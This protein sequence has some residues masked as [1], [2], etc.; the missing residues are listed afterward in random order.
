MSDTYTH[1]TAPLS[2][3]SGKTRAYMAWKSIPHR[4]QQVS[5]SVYKNKIVPA[6]GRP[7]IP[8]L[9][10]AD[11]TVVQDTTEIIDFLEARYPQP[12]I[13]PDGPV[14]KLVA[15]LME[16]YGDEW[17]LIP[18]M[19]YRWA[20]NVPWVYG[21]FG[22]IALPGAPG[23]LRRFVGKLIS[24]KFRGFVPML[25]I[26]D[27]TIPAIEKSYEALLAELDAH[28]AQHAYLLGNRPSIGDYGLI[29]PL[30]AHLY[31]DPAS[32]K[33]MKRLAPHVAAWVERVEF[34]DTP[35]QGDFLDGDQVP[36]TLLPI[37]RRQMVEQMPVLQRTAQML[38]EWR[39]AHP[40]AEE[41]PRSLG[42]LDFTMEGVTGQRASVSYSLWMLQ[43]A[44]DHY[45]SLSQADREAADALLTSVGGAAFAQFQL[46]QR[47]ARCNNRLIPS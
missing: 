15:L 2:L 44:L 29:G 25:G 17:V 1:I 10:C 38:A 36:D 32:G 5:R 13:Y 18:A 37:L 31:R 47:V 11:G 21:E 24:K 35:G 30:Y 43:R 27:Q 22:A 20:Y 14:Q 12:S 9:E 7:V 34:P 46:P 8:V 45:L 16:L 3:Y 39:T 28:F 4:E 40:D 6:V 33:T 23:F 42:N 19:H 41:I 26:T